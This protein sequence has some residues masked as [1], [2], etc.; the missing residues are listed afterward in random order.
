VCP[1]RHQREMLP[2]HI[3]V[4]A[5]LFVI[6]LMALASAS[7]LRGVVLFVFAGLGP[8]LLLAWLLRARLRRRRSGL[9]QDVHGGDA[10]DTQSDQ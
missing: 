9:E 10:R 5:W 1:I 7:A 4:I 2:M 6:G 8:V 3:V